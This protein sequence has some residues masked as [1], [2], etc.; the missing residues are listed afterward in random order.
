MKSSFKFDITME[1]IQCERRNLT[2]R[3]C[4]TFDKVNTLDTAFLNNTIKLLVYTQCSNTKYMDLNRYREQGHHVPA[5]IF[6]QARY[7][8][9]TRV[10]SGRA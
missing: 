2:M 7:S 3:R 4:Q 9:H 1:A 8:H 6:P 10:Y 5:V